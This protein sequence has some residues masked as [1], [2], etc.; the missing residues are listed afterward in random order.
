MSEN[1]EIKKDTG[2]SEDVT[3]ET[4]ESVTEQDTEEIK[5]EEPQN[6]AASPKK[7]KKKPGRRLNTKK[8][9]HGSLSVVF[10][11]IFI[12]AVVLVNV[13][14]NLVLDRFNVE[15]DLTAGNVFTLGAETEQYIKGVK[16]DVTL[17]VTAEEDTLRSSGETLYEQIA[18]FLERMSA[19]NG[20]VKVQY[21]NLLTDPDFSNKFVEDLK[22]YQIIVQ[23]GRTERY[24]ILTI[25]DF[26]RFKLSDGNT[27]SYSEANMYVSY[28]GLT[29][30]DYFSN[31]EEQ[32]VSAIM[33][34]TKED[35]TVVTFL[36]GY[37]ESDSS[38]LEK[39]LTDNAY[40]VK[41]TEIDRVEKIPEETDILVMHGPTKDYS[42]EAITKID[43]WLSNGGSYGKDLVYISTPEAS[44]MPHLDEYLAEWGLQ[45]GRGY[46]IQFDSDHAYSTGSPLPLMQ[47]IELVTDTQ[48]YKS[49]KIASGSN[50]IGYYVRPVIKLFEAKSNYETTTIAKAYGDQCL[51][52]PFEADENW[53]PS[54]D[55]LKA[56]DVIVESAKATFIDNLPVY[57][58]VIA[59][60]SDQLFTEYFTTASNY[61][62]GEAALSLFD[63]NSDSEKN[64][65]KIVEKSFKAETY[66]LDK[67]TQIGIGVTFAIVIPVI[68]IIVG[69]IVWIKRRRL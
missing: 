45:T 39:I 32:I 13:I 58:K 25:S 55:D 18:E 40:D 66:Q 1:E 68:I 69:I 2:S 51:L 24:R 43:E 41:K 65:I 34:V 56:Y 21:V 10:T 37:D 46:I 15:A 38:A 23:S 52:Y 63:A 67:G 44:E 9:K 35:P 54:K 42:L 31:A 17:Y 62:N 61:S 49:M 20:S 60:G 50:F 26:L 22:N 3:E 14:L 33:S 4:A 28:G 29:V 36:T 47:D 6:E 64:E 59:V 19:L 16:D 7:E 30:E 27:Y 8:L 5:P 11:L 53:K 48:Y 57:S 12:A